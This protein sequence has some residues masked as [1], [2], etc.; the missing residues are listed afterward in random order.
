MENGFFDTTLPVI[1]EMGHSQIYTA[2]CM[3]LCAFGDEKM[4]E[5]GKLAAAAFMEAGFV[6]YALKRLV[7][8]SR[9]LDESETNSFPSGHTTLAFAMATVA[10]YEYTRLRIPLYAG[11]LATAF[12][13]IYLGRHYPSDVLA[14]AI[15]GTLAGLQ[16]IH[17]RK[18]ILSFSF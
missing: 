11:A 17:Y 12:A 1:Q 14:G 2:T 8:R 6:A 16:M 18:A 3:L 13:R 15:I 7:G 9:P 10:G 5:T 4:E